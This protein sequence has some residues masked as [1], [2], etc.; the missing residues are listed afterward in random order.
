MKPTIIDEHFFT[1]KT[2]SI[3]R[4]RERPGDDLLVRIKR[5][6]NTEDMTAPEAA[7]LLPFPCSYFGYIRGRGE[8]RRIFIEPTDE[9]EGT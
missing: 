6:P 3:F 9:M 8:E 7:K 5:P 4:I 1:D 2:V